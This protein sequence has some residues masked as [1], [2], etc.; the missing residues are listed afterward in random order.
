MNMLEKVQVQL[1]QLS[2]SERK[3]ADVILADPD[4]AIHSSIAVLAL[5]A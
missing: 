4:R 5:E 2:N 3:V 1:E